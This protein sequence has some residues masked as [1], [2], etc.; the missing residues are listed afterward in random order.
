MYQ[1]L[2]GK[3]GF[4]KGMDLYFERHDGT[5][6]TCD[7]FRAAM[8]DANGRDLMQF[9]RW[10]TQAGTPTVK[11][12]MAYD[13]A[14]KKLTV[15]LEQSC[16]PSPGQTTKEP[17]HIPIRTGLI[18]KDSRKELVEERVLELTQAKQECTQRVPAC[19]AAPARVV[20]L[21]SVCS[22]A[23]SNPTVRTPE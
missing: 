1:T 23:R 5:A 16:G 13:K 10:Y 21:G 8:A 15:T 4:R 9:E 11:A 17:Y 18:G 19:S 14:A 12:T 2:L 3:E 7:D 6:V 22:A 20:L